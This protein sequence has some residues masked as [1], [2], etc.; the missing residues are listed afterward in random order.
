M[1]G[2]IFIPLISVFDSKGIAQA[3]TGL[4]SLAGAV[5]GLGRAAAAGAA[6]Y[7]VQKGIEFIKES[8]GAARDLQAAN[9]GLSGLYGNLAP[10]MQQFTKDAQA[11]GLSQLDASRNVTLLGSSLAA[12]GL[13]IDDVA[14]KTKNLIG[15]SADLAATF[16]LPVDEAV[17]GIGAAFRGEYD[18]IER[19]GVAFKQSQVNALLAARGQ[20]KLKGQMLA[21]AQATARYDLILNATTKTQGNFAKMSDS[22]YGKQ[23]TLTASFENL[24][25]SLGQSLLAPL[26]ALMGALQPIIDLI[27]K[28]LTPV[29]EVFGKIVTVLTPIIDPLVQVIMLLF[30]AL[31]P[32]LDVLA[33]L[34]EPLMFPLVEIFKVL[35]QV[36]KPVIVVIT[37]FARLIGAIVVPVVTVLSLA[38]GIVLKILGKIFEALAAIPFVG[39]AFKSMNDGLKTFTDGIGSSISSINGVKNANNDLVDQL[40]KKLPEPDVSGTTNALDTVTT[41]TKKTAAAV[42]SLLKDALNVQKSIMDSANITGILDNTSH[43]IVKSVVFLNGRFKTLISGVNSGAVDLKTVYKQKFNEIKTFLTNINK[44]TAAHLDP[45]L[46][47]QIASAGPEAGNAT[48]EAI[49]DSGKEGIASLNKTFKGI[50]KVSGDIGVKVAK[51]MT[52]TGNEIGNGLIDG[53]KAQAARLNAVAAGMGKDFGTTFRDN[54]FTGLT[55]KETPSTVP[56]VYPRGSDKYNFGPK[57]GIKTDFGILLNP[58][59]IT[60]PYNKDTQFGAYTRF[61]NAVNTATNYNVTVN[62]AP[63]ATNADVGKA[64][65]NAIQLYERKT[66]KV[67][68]N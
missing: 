28:S 68:S 35:I 57:K 4:A 63:G 18:P 43:E 54:V 49:L 36:L 55:P 37:F 58:S 66:G 64:L 62:V 14:S 29:F 24:K 25:A 8:V 51:A 41:K 19:F 34:I 53:I 10:Q 42:N 27:S 65:I 59:Q 48:A 45:A 22:L 32:I 12:T 1:A 5:K 38:L 11:I 50:T 9:V 17:R 56:K 40:S 23:A 60:N 39:D 46:I 20:N 16:G 21:A 67:F 15:L 3:K 47:A 61:Q 26:A 30:D 6:L 44:L 13:P 33:A 7:G 31:T 52:K 2:S